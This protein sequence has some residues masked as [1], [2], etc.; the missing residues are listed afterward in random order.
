[1]KSWHSFYHKKVGQLGPAL[2][3]PNPPPEKLEPIEED[4]L[5]N[6]LA[7][8]GSFMI[9]TSPLLYGVN[10]LLFSTSLFEG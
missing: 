8:G 4:A 9:D 5:I 10:I 3:A 7:H 2:T 1:M 6:F